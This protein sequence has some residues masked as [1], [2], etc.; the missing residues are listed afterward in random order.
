MRFIRFSM[1]LEC[2]YCG[3]QGWGEHD[4]PEYEESLLG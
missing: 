1:N 3:N 4:C 2:P